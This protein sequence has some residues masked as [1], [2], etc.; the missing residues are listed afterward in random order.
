MSSAER[1]YTPELLG[2]TVRLAAYRLAE[3]LP[4]AGEA[5]SPSCG[6][7]LSLTLD[8]DDRGAISAIGMRVSACAIGQASAAV[9]AEHAVGRD[10]EEIASSLAE[11]EAWVAGEGALPGWPDLKVIAPARDFPGRHGAM[12][13]PWKAAL[14][15]LSKAEAAG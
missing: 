4:L 12:L 14:A 9:F 13:L 3:D 10:A 15:A 5:R 1:L 7:T 6:S 8:T 2:W 11:M